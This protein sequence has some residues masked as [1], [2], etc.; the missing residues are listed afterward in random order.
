MVKK[1]GSTGRD[2]LHNSV[3][4][5]CDSQSVKLRGLGSTEGIPHGELQFVC[6]L[7]S[8]KYVQFVLIS[9]EPSSIFLEAIYTHAISLISA[10]IDETYQTTEVTQLRTSFVAA[11]VVFQ[12][13][14]APQ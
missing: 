9:K 4:C 13:E 8:S 7:L 11:F 2:F 14:A 10:R 6:L 3:S 1:E 12:Q 5:W